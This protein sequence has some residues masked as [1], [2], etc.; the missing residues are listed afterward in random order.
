MIIGKQFEPPMYKFL[1]LVDPAILE[2][3][4]PASQELQQL[5][6]QEPQTQ[7]NGCCQ[8]LS[9]LE[10]VVKNVHPVMCRFRGFGEL[11]FYRNASIG[12]TQHT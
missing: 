9:C 11:F 6:N 1:R 8:E 2:A 3:R 5:A 7:D 12:K 4:Q 10:V